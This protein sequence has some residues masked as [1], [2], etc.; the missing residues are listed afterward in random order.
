VYVCDF[1]FREGEIAEQAE[2]NISREMTDFGR[3]W[4]ADMNF[5]P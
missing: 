4:R 2:E 3:K 1:T 5:S